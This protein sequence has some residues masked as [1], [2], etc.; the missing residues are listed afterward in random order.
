MR[1]A[2]DEALAH[3]QAIEHREDSFVAHFRLWLES[4][5]HRSV[6]HPCSPPRRHVLTASFSFS[7]PKPHRDHVQAV[8]NAHMLHSTSVDPFKLALYKL[9]GKL[10]PSKRNVPLVTATTE[11]WLWYQ[12]AMVCFSS[13]SSFLP[14]H[15]ACVRSMRKRMVVCVGLRTCCSTMENV[16]SRVVAR[17]ERIP[18][19]GLPCF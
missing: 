1:E 5:D 15:R 12:L 17:R 16:I 7:L 10:D 6:T 8:Y 11:D 14:T 3:R 18:A 4:P 2:L 9:M 13:S 19:Y